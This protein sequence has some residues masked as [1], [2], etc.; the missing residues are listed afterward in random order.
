MICFLSEI[1][2]SQTR[3]SISTDLS[4]LRSFKKE[5]RF[6]AGGQ[7][8]VADWQFTPNAGVY[9]SVCYY[10]LGNFKNTL[11]ATAKSPATTPQ[12]FSFSNS[13]QVRFKQISIGGKHYFKGTGDAE[14]GWSIYGKA[15]FGLLYG[16]A[17][18]TYSSAID[19]SLYN[20]P[21]RPVSGKGHFKRL[22]LDLGLGWEVPLGADAFFYT[23]GKV[24][25]P[26][27]EYPSEYLLVNN[28]A[29][30]AGTL[31]AGVRILF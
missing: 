21:Q 15:G 20:A 10:M 5:Q 27:T 2:F 11:V 28:N 4:L 16:N 31:S 9:A 12:Q 13:A 3:V 6:W 25:I 14:Y 29:P 26:T 7:S 30:L 24:W 22:T 8:V 17:V 18:N 23:E 1:A 19:T